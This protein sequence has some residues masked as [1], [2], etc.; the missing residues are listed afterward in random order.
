MNNLVKRQSMKK[1]IWWHFVCKTLIEVKHEV[2][3]VNQSCVLIEAILFYTAK[4]SWPTRP[5]LPHYA[6]GWN[7]GI[8]RGI[9]CHSFRRALISRTLL[10]KLAQDQQPDAAIASKIETVIKLAY[11]LY[12]SLNGHNYLSRNY[13]EMQGL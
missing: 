9:N 8:S 7:P 5:N 12:Q 13:V 2:E 1:T 10:F 3:E 6:T 4:S 11:L